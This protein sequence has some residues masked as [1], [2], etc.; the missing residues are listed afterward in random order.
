MMSKN[1]RDALMALPIMIIGDAMLPRIVTTR[2]TEKKTLD[3]V[4]YMMINKGHGSFTHVI[5]T[6]MLPI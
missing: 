1:G 5:T 2:R 4:R 6:L 3:P